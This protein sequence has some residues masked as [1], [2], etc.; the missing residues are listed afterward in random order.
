[1]V[2]VLP[3]GHDQRERDDAHRLLRVV[4]AVR[5]RH[6]TRREDLAPAEAVAPVGLAV[7]AARDGIRQPGHEKRDH[8]G[9]ERGDQRRQHDLAQHHAEIDRLQARAHQGRA[10]EAA[11]QGVRRT[12]G[13]AQQPRQHVPGDRADKPREDDR[14]EVQRRDLL[15]AD[16]AVRDGLGHLGRQERADEVEARREHDGHLGLERPGRDRRRH[17][18]RGVVEPVGEVEEQCQRDDQHDDEGSG[19]HSSLSSG[20]PGKGADAIG[21]ANEQFTVGSCSGNR[22]R[23]ILAHPP[24]FAEPPD[25]ADA[26]I[27]VDA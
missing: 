2:A 20:F 9:R 8:A 5:E 27:S 12:R 14:Q 4:G 23:K 7:V 11:E 10:D 1:M 19:F 26:S 18:V 21:G 22:T 25:R 6:E 17:R 24:V 16:D 13:Q 3:A 15:F